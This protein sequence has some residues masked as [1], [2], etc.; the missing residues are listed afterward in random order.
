MRESL[1]QK[2]T[3]LHEDLKS[4]HSWCEWIKQHGEQDSG[5]NVRG[6]VVHRL[7]FSSSRYPIDSADTFCAEGWEQFD[8]DQDA[9]YFGFWV[10]TRERLTLTYAEGDW[11]LVVCPTRETYLAEIQDAIRIYGEGYIAKVI[12]CATTE[13]TIF[14]QDR[15]RFLAE[16]PARAN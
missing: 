7:H 1:E 6:N 15:N 5:P 13:V 12:D 16:E 11:H 2:A 8:T 14:R 3:R 9:E 10:N 4:V